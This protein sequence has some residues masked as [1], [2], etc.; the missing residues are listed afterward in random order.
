MEPCEDAPCCGHGG[1]CGKPLG[2]PDPEVSDGPFADM[3]DD[4]IKQSVYDMDE[5][6]FDRGEY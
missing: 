2:Y 4:E 1:V 6:A 5:A 3:T